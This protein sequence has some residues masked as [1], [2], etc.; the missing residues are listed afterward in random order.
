MPVKL[1]L[2]IMR[3]RQ[4]VIKVNNLIFSF[5]FFFFSNII[6]KLFLLGLDNLFQTIVQKT[7]QALIQTNTPE[8]TEENVN[9]DGNQAPEKG[10]GCC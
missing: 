8:S 4:K 2:I 6:Q 1:V 9:V 5:F 10:D 7:Y 3:C